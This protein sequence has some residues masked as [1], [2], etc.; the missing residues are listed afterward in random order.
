MT[1]S[2]AIKIMHMTMRRP[3]RFM[4]VSSGAAEVFWPQPSVNPLPATERP[5]LIEGFVYPRAL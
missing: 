2:A 5:S 3:I 1:A 4:G